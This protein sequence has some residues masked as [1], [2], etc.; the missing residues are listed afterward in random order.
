MIK[1]SAKWEGSK[2]VIAIWTVGSIARR[3]RN[4]RRNIVAGELV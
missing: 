1:G 2:M 3:D 4:A